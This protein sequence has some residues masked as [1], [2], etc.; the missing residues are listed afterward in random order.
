MAAK[1]EN[2]NANRAPDEALAGLGEVVSARKRG[3]AP[4]HLWNPP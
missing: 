1:S 2:E 4:V 3:P